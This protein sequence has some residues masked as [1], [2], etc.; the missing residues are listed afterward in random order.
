[1]TERL[2]DA[3]ARIR[4]IPTEAGVPEPYRSYFADVAGFV[5]ILGSFAEE[6]EGRELEAVTLPGTGG[7][8]KAGIQSGIKTHAETESWL[9]NE[10]ERLRAYHERFYEEPAKAY[11]ASW[12][13]PA[14]AVK[15]LGAYGQL[16][17]CLYLEIRAALPLLYEG[18]YGQL[19]AV[20]ETFIQI[21]C[22]FEPSYCERDRESGA[23]LLPPLQALQDIFYAYCFDYAE[24]ILGLPMAASYDASDDYIRSLI[25]TADLS[26]PDYLYR[27]GE[28]IG[29]NELKISAFLAAQP[30]ERIEQMA[31]ICYQGFTEGFRLAGKP[32][33]RKKLVEILYEPGFERVLKALKACFEADGLQVCIPRASRLLL[34][35]RPG[36]SRGCYGSPNRQLDY[37]H[38]YD[39]ALV[40]G[41]RLASRMLEVRR[42]LY[43]LYREA[44]AV[45]AGPALMESFGELP[46]EPEDKPECLH[47]NEHQRAV[48]GRHRSESQQL[49][50]QYIREEE[51]SFTIIAWPLPSV[52]E[53]FEAVFEEIFKINTMDAALYTQL[54]ARLIDALD[55]ADYVEIRGRR[56]PDGGGNETC[57]RVAL[58]RLADPATQT[59]F[60]N[61][62]ADVNIPLGEVFTSPRL[63][64]TEG[65][66]HVGS[67]YIE[68]LQ[69]KNLRI[70]FEAGRVSDYSCENFEDTEAGRE[71]VR[72]QIFAEKEG[73]PL[74]EFAIGTNTLAYAVAE[75]FGIGAKLPILIAEKMGP[76]FAVG[77][78]CYAF[79]E[80]VRRYNPD[81][82]EIVA[83]ENECSA[84]RD[85]DRKAAYFACHCDITIPYRELDS[86]I[87][88][89]ASGEGIPLI[90]GGRFVLPGT[91]RLND[92]F[93]TL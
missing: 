45:Y 80:E 70:R 56:E 18:K 21:Y 74:G 46:F 58:H 35:R 47:F 90:E 51:R 13:N 14:F 20:L 2:T 57:M 61:C 63:A 76:H 86:I 19:T 60:E 8:S 79:E 24:E 17:S 16:L 11:E 69:F 12:L 53:N 75:R 91:E 48:Y 9:A 7:Q 92:P 42:S 93:E 38:A 29:E 73:L 84:K 36:G 65:L 50:Q 72:K 37:D 52:H 59:N 33:E 4:E 34:N 82:K 49:A 81:G 64:G 44:C 10:A 77:D 54:Q 68:G 26:S 43:E 87:A 6:F 31:R 15:R 27:L 88:Y 32:Y 39:L 55:C 40:W 85:T 62:V 78:T 28:Y 30:Q 25:E 22:Q 5:D 66:L 89:T 1:M 3:L 67:V 41:D 83:K 23:L 71:L